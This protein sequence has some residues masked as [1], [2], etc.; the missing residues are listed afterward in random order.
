[1]VNSPMPHGAGFDDQWCDHA[2]RESVTNSFMGV[3]RMCKT[4]SYRGG[5]AFIN[6]CGGVN[7]VNHPSPRTK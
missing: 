3:V 7:C 1:M 6:I 5:K 4:K 2:A